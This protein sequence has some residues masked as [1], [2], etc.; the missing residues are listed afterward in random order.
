[1][2]VQ[3]VRTTAIYPHVPISRARSGNVVIIVI[4]FFV[5]ASKCETI[6]VVARLHAY[7]INASVEIIFI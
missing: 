6:T 4:K 3:L 2:S 7:Q 5:S 1:M